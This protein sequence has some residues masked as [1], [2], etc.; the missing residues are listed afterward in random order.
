LLVE[1]T[2]ELS[3]VIFSRKEGGDIYEVSVAVK[4]K[5]PFF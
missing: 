4:L 5:M 3:M 1:V 2:N